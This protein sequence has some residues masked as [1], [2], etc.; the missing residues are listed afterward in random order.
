MLDT[1]D[2]PA[3]KAI[4][5]PDIVYKLLCARKASFSLAQIL[6]ACTPWAPVRVLRYL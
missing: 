2:L 6:Y 4:L 3:L 5:L 1:D